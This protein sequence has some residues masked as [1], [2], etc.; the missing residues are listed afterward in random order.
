MVG[1]ARRAFM[2]PIPRARDIDELNAMLQE[3]CRERQQA[4]LRGSEATI[5]DRLEASRVFRRL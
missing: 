5:G 4:V 3:R 2:V 1:F